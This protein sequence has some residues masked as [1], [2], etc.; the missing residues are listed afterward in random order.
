MNGMFY[1]LQFLLLLSFFF[2]ISSELYSQCPGTY[3]LQ[4]QEEI[5]YFLQENP[6]EQFD[7]III[8]SSLG[9]EINSLIPLLGIKKVNFLKFENSC[10]IE[11][12]RGLDSLQYCRLLD[13]KKLYKLNEA[14]CFTV[15]DTVENL[16]LGLSDAITD[17]SQFKNLKALNS[18]QIKGGLLTSFG[19][20]GDS[21]LVKMNGK[22]PS[23]RVIGV[24]SE[25][26]VDNLIPN[27]L[28]S[29]GLLLVRAS[30]IELAGLKQVKHIDHFSFRNL[31][32]YYESKISSEVVLSSVN[33]LRLIGLDINSWKNLNFSDLTTVEQ[34]E[35]TSMENLNSLD[36][37]LPALSTISNGLGLLDN[38]ALTDI[39]LLD[40]IEIPSRGKSIY[41][42]YYPQEVSDFFDTYKDDKIVIVDNSNL[43]DCESK[44]L[45]E[46]IIQYPDSL[47]LLRNGL[48][49]QTNLIIDFCNTISSNQLLLNKNVSIYPNPTK[50][51]FHISG[52]ENIQLIEI[53]DINGKSYPI[54]GD[55]FGMT[56]NIDHLNPGLYF[57]RIKIDDETLVT[58]LN[59]Y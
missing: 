40:G 52:L 56:Y 47:L 18:I 45:C 51:S 59:I 5:N 8:G 55:Q 15:L 20:W 4:T 38:Q 12:L 25:D 2:F 41:V 7:S 24:N 32:G 17:L 57:L 36:E 35:L 39:S 19:G 58:K 31:I 14:N 43:E 13:L 3:K 54:Q 50:A 16:I 23:I 28:D 1:R 29:L 37:I 11:S 9:C 10:N 53:I 26:Q 46:A 22:L 33:T 27:D 44:F 49:C 6:C 21:P 30:S 48:D 42:E 34:L